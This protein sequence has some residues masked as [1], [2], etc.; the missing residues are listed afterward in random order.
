M[1]CVRE[2]LESEWFAPREVNGLVVVPTSCLYPGGSPVRVFV[3]G[4]ER[5]AVVHDDRNAIWEAELSGMDVGDA[6]R[7]VRAAGKKYGV[8]VTPTG[9]IT[10][11]TVTCDML[12]PTVVQV[13]NASREAADL[14]LRD[15]RKK[16]VT[17]ARTEL[18]SILDTH[19]KGRVTHGD[20]LACS[21]SRMRS[22]ENIVRIGDRQHVFDFVKHDWRSINSR[23]VANVDLA[24]LGDDLIDQRIVYDD[25]EDWAADQIGT[26]AIA[27]RPVPF[28]TVS[29]VIERLAA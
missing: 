12:A 18:R 2:A 8:I 23:V 21:S 14:L 10:S 1:K 19:F 27:A 4:G 11:P 9:I 15:P 16:P 25:Q 7:R 24:K 20:V 17:D 3:H 28:S 29:N 13:A 22:F 6:A 5:S 26:L